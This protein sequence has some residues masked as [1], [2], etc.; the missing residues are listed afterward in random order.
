M[1]TV[2]IENAMKDMDQL[3]NEV[4]DSQTPVMIINDQGKNAVLVS[5]QEWQLIQDKIHLNKA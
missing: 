4:N 2:N 1:L 5:E 3:I